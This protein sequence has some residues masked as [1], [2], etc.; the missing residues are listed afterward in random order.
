M[1]YRD[2]Y[3]QGNHENVE[4]YNPYHDHSEPR[5]TYDQAGY[6]E[7]HASGYRDEPFHSPQDP[8]P[9]TYVDPTNSKERVAFGSHK[10][11]QDRCVHIMDNLSSGTN[12]DCS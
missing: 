11:P 12:Y 6:N 3:S 7:Q 8:I 4:Y 2:P 1:S 10:V 9:S 5:P